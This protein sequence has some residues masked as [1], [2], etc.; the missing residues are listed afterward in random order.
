MVK[1]RI[2]NHFQD[3]TKEQLEKLKEDVYGHGSAC[4]PYYLK[5]YNEEK[6]KHGR[7]Y[8][9]NTLKEIKKFVDSADDEIDYTSEHSETFG[10]WDW[11]EIDID[12]D[13]DDSEDNL[14]VLTI[15]AHDEWRD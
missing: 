11:Q 9:F 8:E 4:N 12:L 15:S 1:L 2:V 3:Y 5:P 14:M 10:Q 7:V 6:Y 13:I